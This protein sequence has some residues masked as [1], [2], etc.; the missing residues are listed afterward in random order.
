[1]RSIFGALKVYHTIET[2]V[3]RSSALVAVRIQLL[4]R[5]D[6]AASLSHFQVN[7]KLVCGSTRAQTAHK[8]RTSHENETIAKENASRAN[9]ASDIDFG[10]RQAIRRC[11]VSRALSSHLWH[12]QEGGCRN[13]SDQ[14]AIF[15]L[16]KVQG[17]T[18]TTTA[19]QRRPCFTTE[20]Q[21]YDVRYRLD[22]R[23]LCLDWKVVN[24]YDRH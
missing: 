14:A 3:C 15:A 5:Q 23:P 17:A 8:Q 22:M 21:Q 16:H 6:I 12:A 4:L 7:K 19:A 24:Q 11:L 18:N 1:M 10:A 9:A 2:R 13:V 20:G